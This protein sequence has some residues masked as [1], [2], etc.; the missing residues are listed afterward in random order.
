MRVNGHPGVVAPEQPS[1]VALARPVDGMLS[2]D[3]LLPPPSLVGPERAFAVAA[4]LDENARN[5]PL[6]TAV[7]AIANG[8][9]WTL[10]AHF[11]LSKTNGSSPSMAPSVNAPPAMAISWGR[12]RVVLRAAPLLT[13]RL[14]RRSPEFGACRRRPRRACR[15]AAVARLDEV[16]LQRA[17][18]VL[19]E[20]FSRLARYLMRKGPCFR[21]R[22]EAQPPP[23]VVR[24][25]R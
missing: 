10:C 5:S 6:L 7:A 2:A 1:A 9:T 25:G 23:A 12:N 17:R 13:E 15:C 24:D 14:A 21:P 8:S 4:G 20:P 16:L 22:R 19:S 18:L 3:R 11:S